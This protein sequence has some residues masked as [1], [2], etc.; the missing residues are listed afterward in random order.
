MIFI[1]LL[2]DFYF[3]N[4]IDID[5][6][7]LKRHS[8]KAVLLDIDNTLTQ[9]NG[10]EPYDG[11]CEWVDYIKNVGVKVAIISNAKD[12]NRERLFAEKLRI[13]DCI[14]HAKK[15]SKNGFNQLAKVLGIDKSEVL[16]IGDQIFTDIL[17]ANLAGTMSAL[18]EPKDKKEPLLIKIKRVLELPF[19]NLINFENKK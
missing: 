18:V 11:V 5:I 9:H 1:L 13:G 10:T 14:W 15:P 16:A 4:V 12:K 6:G 7:F 8:I 19:R 3:K 2:P 17:G